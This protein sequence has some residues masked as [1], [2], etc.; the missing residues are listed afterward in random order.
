MSSTPAHTDFVKSLLVI[1]QL[2]LLLSGSSDKT[3]A[4]W[5]LSGLSTT[6]DLPLQRIH[7]LK[8]H[9]RPV[10]SFVL[11]RADERTRQ[12][13]VYAGD[14]MGVIRTW[15][16]TRPSDPEASV[17]QVVQGRDFPGHHTSITRLIM[18]GDVGLISCSMDSQVLYHPLEEETGGMDGETGRK[19][20]LTIPEPL[21]GESTSVRSL[22][23]LPSTFH[24]TPLLLCG[25]SD[26]SI[27][28]FAISS[29]TDLASR[30]YS[31]EQIKLDPGRGRARQVS[32]IEGHW[33]DVVDLDVWVKEVEGGKKE[34]W[35]VS[36]S[37]DETLR[38]WSMQGRGCRR[39]Q[40]RFRLVVETLTPSASRS[41]WSDVL[42][43]PAIPKE[44]V[45]ETKSSLMTEE[46]ERE[47]AELMNSDIDEDI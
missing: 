34:A 43:P 14:S 4:V 18:D 16:F 39:C 21:Y 3:I 2:D 45:V 11:A 9:T 26:Q 15:S 12:A 24:S 7:Q 5:S 31:S 37:L 19:P 32:R 47:L 17:V 41:R 35:V 23:L 46:E 40:C 8:S 29:T 28:V 33:A 25:A 42:T 30:S 6:S 1:P 13:I 10:D 36:A 44:Q 22:L 38:R 27:R 20:A